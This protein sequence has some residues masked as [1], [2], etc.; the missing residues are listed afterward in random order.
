[1]AR[2]KTDTGGSTRTKTP[3]QTGLLGS[4]LTIFSVFLILVLATSSRSDMTLAAKSSP[5]ELKNL[6]GPLGAHM[7]DLFLWT[8]GITAFMLAAIL[9]YIG[10]KAVMLRPARIT[11]GP[12]IW[13]VLGLLS[14]ATLIDI[15]LRDFTLFGYP[16]A[17]KLGIWAGPIT[18][19]LLSKTGAII[20][21][22]V[23]FIISMIYLIGSSLGAFLRGFGRVTKV[24]CAQLWRFIKWA[25][26]AIGRSIVKAF[27]PKPSEA[28]IPPDATIDDDETVLDPVVEEGPWWTKPI[29]NGLESAKTEVD[30]PLTNSIKIVPPS[31]SNN[32]GMELLFDKTEVDEA[33]PSVQEPKIVVAHQP[34]PLVEHIEV[35]RTLH[36]DPPPIDLLDPVR[37]TDISVDKEALK[38]N[39]ETLERKLKDYKVEG[40]VV[41]IHPGPVVTMYEFLPAPGVKIS[42]IAN[43]SD[44]LKMALE[45]INI[46][47]VAPIPGKGV[48][49]IEVPNEIRQTVYLREILASEA[50]AKAKSKLTLALGKDIF[51]TPVVTDLSRMPHL[52]I[53]GATG[54]GKSVAVNAFI[55]SLL[56]KASPQDIRMILVDPKVVELQVY[57]DI[58]HLLLPVVSDP[59]QA[60]AALRWAVDEMERR[61]EL[62]AQY[63]VRNITSYNQ[64]IDR[65]INAAQRGDGNNESQLGLE[66]T[67]MTVVD[68]TT[69]DGGLENL[70]RLPFIV[71]VLDEFADL[72]SVASKEVETAVTRLAQKARAAGIHLIMATQRPSREVITGLIKAN[73]PSRIGFSVSSKIDSRIILD[74]S[75]A[76]ALLGLGDMLFLQPGSS[77][78]TRIHGPFVSDD[79][80][81]RVTE[82][83]KRQGKP[84]YH[85]EIL[86]DLEEETSDNTIG[87]DEDELLNEAQDI[88][89]ST[90]RASISFLQRRL[91]IG[92]NRAARIMEQLEERKVV[93]PQGVRG[94]REVIR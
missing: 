37:V 69:V 39:A 76:E 79:E 40:K 52:L 82:H 88:V 43:L 77:L 58:P 94:E 5:E 59:K 15:T 56:T 66:L 64:R 19:N 67:G 75:G 22:S 3:I 41:E 70:E 12:V 1:M 60:A 16:P 8:M 6:F 10:V 2:K 25:G 44:D 34:T 63:G 35:E 51:G 90:G 24:I 84:D 50:F 26:A 17:G 53:A 46:R 78:V 36:Y 48:V 31:A 83:L 30:Q 92:F 7:A 4:L 87:A 38:R 14:F 27:T 54:S 47:I 80:V 32:A 13:S 42:Q 33:E 45:A 68:K 11:I 23:I 91:N 20:V 29:P 49:G 62:L 21:S 55:L 89:L 61:Y 28:P 74:Q 93:G 72:M 57:Q 86:D 9:L 18:E 85:M 81:T 65:M 73:F 71:I